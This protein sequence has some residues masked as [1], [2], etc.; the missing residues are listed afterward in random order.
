MSS[1]V[2]WALTL[3]S[4]FYGQRVVRGQV[5]ETDF[6]ID[7]IIYREGVK[8]FL[9]GHEM[10]SQPMHAGDIALP[11]IYPP[12]GALVMVPLTA[13]DSITNDK[14]GNI[15][16]VLSDLLLLACLYFVLRAV[17]PQLRQPASLIPTRLIAA[18]AVCWAIAV[19]FE[20][21]RLN[22]GFA[23]INIVIMALVVFDLVPRR[24]WLPQGWLIGIAAAI[25]LSPIAMLLY[26]LLRRQYR[27]IVSAAVSAL[28]ATVLAA[29]VRWDATW[30]FFSVKLLAM[31]SGGDVGVGTSY[32]SNSS[33]K[34]MLQRAFDTKDAMDSSGLLINAAWLALVVLTI[35]LGSYLMVQLMRRG[36]NTEAWLTNAVI[37]LF[38]SPISWS[39]HWIWL[40][41]L[42]P[43]FTYRA[44]TWRNL[45]WSAGSL[46]VV[47]AAW[48][49]M[50]VSVPPKWWFGDDIDVFGLDFYQKFLVSDFLWLSVL[51]LACTA[52]CLPYLPITDDK[53]T[54]LTMP[55]RLSALLRRG[56]SS[57]RG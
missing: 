43:V 25:K 32:Q 34:A 12:F 51:A 41:I 45:H 56:D 50:L 5:D 42:V 39:H 35:A 47:M 31:G 37:M 36:L 28:L 33:I 49:G 3:V 23:Q 10:Y 38:I 18:T 13:F 52:R 57:Q 44:W 26:F 24:R 2:L 48:L 6:P 30:E 1:P 16:I 17:A 15:M 22:N 46:I 9:N 11:F 14:A 19:H 21:V 27:A 8:A 4:L 55:P 20:P 53:S 40:T 7:M 29:A 54:R